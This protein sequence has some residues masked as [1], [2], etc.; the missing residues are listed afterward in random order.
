MKSLELKIPPPL[1]A[2]LSILLMWYV[3]GFYPLSWLTAA[4][5][6][7][8]SIVMALAGIT[9]A[10][11]GVVEFRRAHTTVNPMHPEQTSQLVTRGIYQVTR[12]PM[13]L[14]MAI[15]LLGVALYLADV[16]AFLGVLLFVRYIGRYQIEPEEAILSEKFGDG[17]AAYQDQVRRWL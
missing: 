8:L 2:L 1:I 9:I 16:S 10:V 7:P 6:L 5:V 17:F 3:Q 4:W 14:G 12:N 13:Y 11:L 15:V